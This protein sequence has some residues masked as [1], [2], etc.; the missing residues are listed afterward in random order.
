MKFI[1]YSIKNTVVVRFLVFLL[2]IGGI[3]SYNKLGKLEDPEF[4]IKEALVIT[5]YPEADAHT[6][7]LQVTDKI[8]EAVNKLPNIDY[9]QSVSKPGY[10]EVKIKLD[11]WFKCTAIPGTR[12]FGK[13]RVG[14]TV[15]EHAC[16]SSY[17]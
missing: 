2:I 16:K 13:L 9:I 8:E 12:P 14:R 17:F 5:L 15:A 7:E 10:S 11:C 4:K 3:F 6:V 1:D